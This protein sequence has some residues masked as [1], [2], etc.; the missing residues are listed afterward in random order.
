MSITE[1]DLRILSIKTNEKANN[2]NECMNFSQ[3]LITK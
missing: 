2:I 1:F 3:K